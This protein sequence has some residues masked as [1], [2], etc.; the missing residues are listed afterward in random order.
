M[1]ALFI[2]HHIISFA[3]SPAIGFPFPD[4]VKPCV[5]N[6]LVRIAHHSGGIMV[7]SVPPP[8]P[9][10]LL[11]PLLACLPTAFAS[12]RPPSA[13]L[14][15]VSPILRQ[16]LQFIPLSS[17]TPSENWL[18]LL[19][20]DKE[21]ADELIVVVGNG[22][23]EPHPTSGEIEIGD[24]GAIRYKRLDQATLRSQI[25]LSEWSLTALY[26]WCGESEGGS[27]WK[28]AELIP[29]D[30]DLELSP[31]WSKSIT[32]ANE[33]SRGRMVSEALRDAEVSE[34][35]TVGEDDDDNYW[36]QYDKLRGR[37]LAQN[38]S[39]APVR[40]VSHTEGNYY[41][42]YNE[43]LPTMDIYDPSEG[44][45]SVGDSSLRGDILAMIRKRQSERMEN[46]VW[47]QQEG[48]DPQPGVVQE[49]EAHVR[50][51][52]PSAL[53]GSN[54]VRGSEATA[55]HQSSTDVGIRRHI[56]NSLKNLYEL[57]CSAGMEREEFNRIILTELG[58]HP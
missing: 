21:K 29:Y 18:R 11:P 19:C 17:A 33:S 12:H 56:S 45:N 50:H 46:L 23:Y 30:R 22:I 31:T 27:S 41:A 28:L 35:I 58:G 51:L 49:P 55:D 48:P 47:T 32:E 24:V 7:E 38:E 6:G 43:V 2:L 34:L 20:W 54:A 37:P 14:D 1:V 3:L 39:P 40:G 8:D 10:R 44:V 52:Q 42:Q 25:V 5:P 26:L 53:A 9:Q 16:R 36:A 15:L 4:L 13:L 57:A